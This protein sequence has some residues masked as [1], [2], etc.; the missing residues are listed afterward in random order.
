MSSDL[1]LT[2]QKNA[3]ELRRLSAQI[4]ESFELRNK[5]ARHAE[6]WK[7]AC[8]ELHRQYSQLA[9]PGGYDGALE[10]ISAGDPATIEAALCFVECRPYFFRSGYMYKDILRRLKRAPLESSNAKRMA[11]I[12]DAYDEYRRRRRHHGE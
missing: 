3:E 12:V 9:F 6:K 11:V 5:S 1:K 10:R 4:D 8:A 2:I 7:A